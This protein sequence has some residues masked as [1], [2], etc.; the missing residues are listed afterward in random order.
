[1]SEAANFPVLAPFLLAGYA[2]GSI[3]FGWIIGRLTGKDIRKSGSGNIG[4]TNVA[5]ASGTFYGIAAFILDFLKGVLIVLFAARFSLAAS[6]AAGIAVVFGHDFSL[7]LHL[8]G[9][10][11]I[12][13]TLG[14]LSVWSYP[15]ALIS[16]AAWLLTFIITKISSLSSIVSILTMA[17]ASY[18]IG[19]QFFYPIT[20]LAIL[21][22]F[23]HRR[24]INRLLSKQEKKL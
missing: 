5:R 19:K 16:I 2:A 8:K 18:F 12:S 3:P 15:I 9:G 4:A 20:F 23:R 21:A 1:M 17:T 10:K 24:N 22:I 11:G 6:V 7:F 14:V 13:T